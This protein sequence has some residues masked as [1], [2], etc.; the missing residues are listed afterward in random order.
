MKTKKNLKRIPFLFLAGVAAFTLTV[1]STAQ[2]EA[3]PRDNCF[4][5]QDIQTL[6]EV[7]QL[8]HLDL[9]S[10]SDVSEETMLFWMSAVQGYCSSHD[11]TNH[12]PCQMRRAVEFQYDLM[13]SALMN[14]K[15]SSSTT[16]PVTL[17][18]P[19]F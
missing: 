6:H 4:A 3:A 18:A 1:F 5:G 13:A 17:S 7:G 19:I 2:E 12:E 8:I 14:R 9:L 15:S 10:G 16:I 11:A